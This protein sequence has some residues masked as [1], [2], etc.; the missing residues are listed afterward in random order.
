MSDNIHNNKRVAKNTL[1][2]YLRTLLVMAVTI[3]TSRVVLDVLG[4]DDY[5]IYNVVGG[6]VSMFSVLSGTLTAASQRFIAYE[7]GCK[8]PNLT[9]VFSTAITIHLVLAVVIFILLESIGIWFLNYKMNISPERLNAANWVFQCSV[10]TFCVSL[11]SIPYNAA[12]VAYEK[13]SAFAYISIFEVACKLVGVFGLYYISFDSL[14][15]YAIFMMLVAILLRIIY[16]CYCNMRFKQCKFVFLF[17]KLTF[18]KMLGFC[19]WNFIGSSAAVLNGQGINILFNLFFGVTLNAARGIASQVESAINTF[20]QNFMMA[21]NPQITKSYASGDFKYVNSIILTGT[22]LAFFLLWILA[23]PVCLNTEYILQIWLK[24]VPDY[25]TCFIQLGLVY[26]LFQNLSQCLYTTMLATGNIKKY[27]IVV[28][29][30]SILAFPATYLFFWFG[31]TVEWGYYSMIMFSAICLFA[32]L[33]LMKE[34]VPSFSPIRFCSCVIKPITICVISILLVTLPIHC[35]IENVNG[36]SFISESV[37]SVFVSLI[38]IWLFG[39]T[40]LER[41]KIQGFVIKSIDKYKNKHA[42]E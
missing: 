7:L 31:F 17:D 19:G 41:N 2:L 40:K 10:V 26:G 33:Y 37:F 1:Y 6:F 32:R 5:G 34:M 28:G 18:S 29:G 36:V 27:Q 16:G 20:V 15:V 9:K 24:K 23:L 11:I 42:H 4:V 22:K 12:I 13:M 39:L 25:A 3:Y 14:I 21:L 35:Y 30:L 38:F 8:K